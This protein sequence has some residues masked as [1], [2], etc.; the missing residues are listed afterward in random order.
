MI[1]SGKR[2]SW[3]VGLP[4]VM[5]MVTSGCASKK[6]VNAQ[7]NQVNQKLGQ[8]EKQTNDKIAWLNRKQ[9]SDVAALNGRIGETDQKLSELANA[10][11]ET[12]GT[13]SQAMEE[14]S[15]SN[16]TTTN[17]ETIVTRP[18]N[19]QMIDKAEV[20]FGFN[21]ATLTPAG[22]AALDEI[23]SKFQANPTAI[24]E[25][26]GFTDQVGSVNYN[27]DLSRRRA[28]AVQRY[29]VDHKVPLRSITVVGMGKARA[30]EGLEPQTTGKSGRDG[31]NPAERRVNI[32]IFDTSTTVPTGDQN[33]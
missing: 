15:R 32:R 10:V 26:A 33:Q 1:K 16:N 18:T 22:T 13:A 5:V 28:W 19:Y 27:L 8:Y 9:D 14:A 24:V 30:P 20:M 12:Q 6:Y 2:V 29:L 11:Q 31:R 21:K 25:L 17:M 4:I 23:A 7:F 3:I